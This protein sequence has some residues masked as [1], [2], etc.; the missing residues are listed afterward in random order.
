[1]RP[2]TTS[3]KQCAH[4]STRSTITVTMHLTDAHL[5]HVGAEMPHIPPPP[6]L[7]GEGGGLCPRA[8]EESYKSLS[9]RGR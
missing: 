6:S 1:M 7:E 5:L 9:S 4:V 2:A 3:W 8:S